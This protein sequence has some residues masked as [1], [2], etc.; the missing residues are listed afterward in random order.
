MSFEQ[1]LD[2]ERLHFQDSLIFDLHAHPGLNIS[3]FN[4]VLTKRFYPSARAFDPFSVRTNYS[5]FESRRSGYLAL[6]PVC[7]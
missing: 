4:R 5:S 2:W 1:N 6:C 3:L 7:A